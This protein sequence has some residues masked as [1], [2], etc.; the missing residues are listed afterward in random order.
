MAAQKST[1]DT[2]FHMV[3]VLLILREEGYAKI[4][5]ERMTSLQWRQGWFLWSF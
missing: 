2:N 4:G 1:I 3:L 5:F